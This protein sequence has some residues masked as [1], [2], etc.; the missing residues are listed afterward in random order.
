[1]VPGVILYEPVNH[2]GPLGAPALLTRRPV[3]HFGDDADH[4]DRSGQ[5]G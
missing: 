5:R 4:A 2:I 1:M 3:A